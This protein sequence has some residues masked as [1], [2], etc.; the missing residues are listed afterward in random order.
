MTHKRCLG[1]LFCTYK[2]SDVCSSQALSLAWSVNHSWFLILSYLLKTRKLS[3][4]SSVSSELYSSDIHLTFYYNNIEAICCPSYVTN[5]FQKLDPL[6]VY[7]LEISCEETCVTHC[8]V[9]TFPYNTWKACC[10]LNSRRPYPF[11]YTSPSYI[12]RAT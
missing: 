5:T 12:Q 6:R 8:L 3:T 10:G 1:Y 4:L 7:L 11:I 9:S 2:K